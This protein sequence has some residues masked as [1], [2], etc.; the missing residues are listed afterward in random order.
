M[1]SL[2]L[3]SSISFAGSLNLDTMSGMTLYNLLPEIGK[4]VGFYLFFQKVKK[5]ITNFR[6]FLKNT[7]A[8]QFGE[9][10][11]GHVANLFVLIHDAKSHVTYLE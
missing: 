9:E 10:Q 7:F 11:L 4:N 1:I 2:N 6:K 8:G 5:K 3:S